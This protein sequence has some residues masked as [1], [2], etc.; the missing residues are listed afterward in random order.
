VL[1]TVAI[2]AV[3][4]T[5]VYLVWRIGWTLPSGDALWLG[6]PFLALELHGFVALTLFVVTTWNVAPTRERLRTPAKAGREPSVTV[7]IATYDERLEV[8]LPTVAAV[9]AMDGDHGTWILDDGDRAEVAEMAAALGARYVTR[10]VHD[11]AKAG[12]LNHALRMV[13][14]DL[15]AVFDA[16]HVPEPDF[17]TRTVPYF[18][19]PGLALVQTPQDFYNTAS[20]EHHR[21][22]SALHEES[23]FYRVI[24]AGKHN[25]GAAFWCGTNAVLRV[26]ALR[27]VGGVATE[28][29][30]EDFHTTLRLHRAGWRTAYHNEVLASGLAAGTP[31]VFYA[32]RRRW[33]RGAMQVLRT[34]NP[35]T[36]PGLTVAQRL[37]YAYSLSAWFDSWRTLALA[38]LPV[39]VLVTGL[40]P[41]RV[42]PWTF[43]LLAGSAFVLQQ[44]AITMLGRGFARASF[45]LLFDMV[46]LPSNLAATVTLLRRGTGTFAVTAK[47]RTG[48][49]RAR[50]RAPWVL[51]TLA[52]VLFS[53]VV[54]AGLSLAGLTPTRY[55]V[56][57]TAAVPLLW[58]LVTSS[59]VGTAI[60]RIRS[61]RFGAE[62]REG[63]RFP[64]SFPATVD[65]LPGRMIDVS[66]G[67]AQVSVPGP[68]LP[69][70][71]E[72]LLAM[73]VPD[74]SEPIIFEVTVC[75]RQEDR[76]RLE[77]RVRDWR[78]LAALSATA[79]AV[80]ALAWAT[81]AG[82]AVGVGEPVLEPA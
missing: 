15:I 69:L 61:L 18:G 13:T 29:L 38:L 82:E 28:S 60:M 77:F 14:T 33:G 46:R 19:D 55:P 59:F 42:D 73:W 16:D 30:T 68:G 37:S 43:L 22:G 58:L 78:A 31:D 50:A 74:R 76:H 24:Q 44:T 5:L 81:D 6:L 34:D 35:L 62:R 75:S 3:A 48:E 9:L 39:A 36:G 10:P 51:A 26:S 63:H 47:G 80:G 56:S 57:G 23:L 1:H 7:V 4:C 72:T 64:V 25:A 21:P 54:Y 8:L 32:Q 41:V 12:N 53:A 70:G 2:G 67:G 65:G 17:L 11:H 45:S 79:M 20:F 49:E 52:L 40:F 71:T 27:S 66:L